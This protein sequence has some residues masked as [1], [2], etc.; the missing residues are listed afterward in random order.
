M[1]PSEDFGLVPKFGVEIEV[2]RWKNRTRTRVCKDLIEAELMSVDGKFDE[3]FHQYHCTCRVCRA[4]ST[5]KVPWPIQVVQQ[6]DASLPDEGGEFITSP[7]LCTELFMDGFKTVWDTVAKSADWTMNV[8]NRRGT[9]SSP[10]I[11][12]HVSVENPF[13]EVINARLARQALWGFL[14]E[15]FAIAGVCG[16][17]RGVE[18]RHPD[19]DMGHHSAINIC[20]MGRDED[21]DV[22]V[23][24]LRQVRPRERNRQDGMR[25]EWRIWEAAYT[26][27][28]YTEGVVALSCAMTQLVANRDM[29]K[30]LDTSATLLD[31]GEYDVSDA[32]TT[33]QILN[34]FSSKRF[35]FLTE[36]VLTAPLV[37][38]DPAIYNAIATLLARVE[39]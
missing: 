29:A 14:P 28:E 37:Q 2:V 22:A 5:G 8:P 26:D 6:Y 20:S 13:K 33:A 7:M 12:V 3:Q 21:G 17:D 11:H 16:T 10:S 4:W 25:L 9:P 32:N 23:T 1:L 38:E 35:S 39:R 36:T 31:D 15:L 19:P 30:L 27:W 24:G 34:L 18:F